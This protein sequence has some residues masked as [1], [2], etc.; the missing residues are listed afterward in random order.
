MVALLPQLRANRLLLNPLE[1]KLSLVSPLFPVATMV[2]LPRRLCVVHMVYMVY[3]LF[4]TTVNRS[5]RLSVSAIMPDFVVRT[6]SLRLPT[7]FRS[8]LPVRSAR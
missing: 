6:T 8:S 5:K 7:C 2:L 4:L 3:R 1:L